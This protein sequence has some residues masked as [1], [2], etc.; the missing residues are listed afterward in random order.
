MKPLLNACD[1]PLSLLMNRTPRHDL[2]N[3]ILA[4]IPNGCER[5]IDVSAGDHV[6]T[7]EFSRKAKTVILNDIAWDTL[8]V[9]ASRV[10]SNPQ[11]AGDIIFTNE[12][13]TRAPF[14]K[15]AF[16][17]VYCRNTLHHFSRIEELQSVLARLAKWSNN[18]VII[19]EVLD[20]RDGMTTWDWL[21]DQYYRRFL[22]DVGDALLPRSQ[23]QTLM[24]STFHQE[25]WTHN[26]TFHKTI[27]GVIA[28]CLA[29]RVANTK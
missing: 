26:V 27:G 29:E 7:I 2:K 21:R 8:E 28:L 6:A 20:P 18:R 4:C 3:L 22:G 5:L 17:V 25:E 11:I 24:A 19:A 1:R 14:T 12:D 13:I 23:F 10:S 9:L 15:G 16:D